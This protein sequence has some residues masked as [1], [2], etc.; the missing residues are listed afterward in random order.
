MLS[1]V[2]FNLNKL[3]DGL[4][5]TKAITKKFYLMIYVKNEKT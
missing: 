3:P 4:K 2:L 5:E 1:L